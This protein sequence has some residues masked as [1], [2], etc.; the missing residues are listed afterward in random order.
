MKELQA[1]IDGLAVIV[2]ASGSEAIQT[3]D[4]RA[5][6]GLLRRYAPSQ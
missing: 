3:K 2:I 6:S 4:A 1:D 5:Q